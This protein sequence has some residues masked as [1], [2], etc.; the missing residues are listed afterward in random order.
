MK[1]CVTAQGPTLEAPVDNR[2]GRCANFI[3]IDPD[4]MQFDV[5]PNPGAMA[6]GGAGIQ[7]AQFVVD[8]KTDVVLTGHLGPNAFDALNSSGVQM[9]IG[10]TGTVQNAINQFQAGQLTAVSSPTTPA[11]AGMGG[12]RGRGRGRGRR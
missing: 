4:T 1:I 6:S 5:A 9:F 2:F 8:R 10:V 12:G 11:H 7:A 3:F